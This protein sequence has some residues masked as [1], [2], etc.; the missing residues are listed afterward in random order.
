MACERFRTSGGWIHYETYGDSNRPAL[1]LLHGFTGSTLTWLPFA[2]DLCS[3]YHVVLVDLWGHGRSSSPPDSSRYSMENQTADLEA[4]FEEL[5]LSS[6]LL[7]GYSMGGRTALGYATAYPGRLSGLVLESA[8]PGLKTEQERLARIRHDASLAARLREEPLAEFVR[9][10]ENIAL[11]DTQKRLSAARQA[12]IREERLQQ[13]PAGLANSLDGI[14]T[15]R[16]PSYWQTLPALSC[17]VLLVT[18]M[19][20]EKFTRIAAEM[21]ALLPDAVHTQVADAGHAVHV[22]KPKE[23]ATIVESFA[24]QHSS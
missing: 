13:E 14:G 7:I 8:S 17:P 3:R 16:Q 10:W 2:R 9:F 5:E 20:D 11:F 24:A 12:V 6:L 22:E 23:F 21:A 15:G 19:L 1:V 18:G 4:L